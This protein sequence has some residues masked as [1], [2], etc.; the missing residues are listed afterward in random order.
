MAYR[1]TRPVMPIPSA[2]LAALLDPD[3]LDAI[4]SGRGPQYGPPGPGPGIVYGPPLVIEPPD[5]DAERREA[6][7]RDRE[8]RIA[9]TALLEAAEPPPTP[10]PPVAKRGAWRP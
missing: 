10:D 8:A 2:A 3:E 7:A 9:A 6:E 4:L 1:R 5:W